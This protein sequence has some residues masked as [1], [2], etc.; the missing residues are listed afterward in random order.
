MSALNGIRV[1]D[2]STLLP[3]PFATMWLADLGAD[4]VRVEAPDRPDLVR[5]RPP[6]EDG[7]SAGHA[8]LNRNKRSIAIDL[9]R[10]G[11]AEVVQ[12]IARDFDVVI[13]Q[14]RPGVMERLG[15]GYDALRAVRPDVIY[16]SLT[17]YGQNGPLRDRAGHDNNYLALA[18]VMSHSGRRD[19]GPP[20]L[21]VQ[22]A[23]LGAG[24]FGVMI[25]VLAAIVHRQRTGEG[26]YVDVSMFDGSLMWNAYAAAACLVGGEAPQPESMPLNGGSHY[27]FYRTRDGRYFSV[28]SLEPQF[29]RGFCETMGHPE[30][31]EHPAAPGPHMDAIKPA[32]RAA[33]L[34]KTFEEWRTIFAER[35][36]CVEPVLDLNEAFAHPQTSA[37][38]M[39]AE[40]PK[41]NG[42]TQRQ[43]AHPV[44]FS[45]SRTDYRHIGVERGAHTE[46]I[47]R[48]AGYGAA[49]IDAMRTAGL[50]GRPD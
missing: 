25:G 42:G 19:E 29:W 34:E 8:F 22:V 44:K 16:C 37:R 30:W 33:F 40:V 20:P 46:E 39:I 41:P 17:G 23:D 10:D 21:G 3:G 43:V 1:L 28:G 36:V 50:F 14:F 2:F 32:I 26:Q 45:R 38:G 5:Q 4:V 13:E 6:F 31:A 49:D 9:K 47:L 11:A 15:L 12:R 24:S 18:G 48:A 35:D 27:D 7:V